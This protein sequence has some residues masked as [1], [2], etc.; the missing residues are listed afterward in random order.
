MLIDS[1]RIYK[2][3]NERNAIQRY[4][5]RKIFKV[6]ERLGFH[7]VGDHF[8]EPIPN[9]N[10]IRTRYAAGPRD[11]PALPHASWASYNSKICSLLRKHID[12]YAKHRDFFGYRENNYYFYGVDAFY[13][14]AL[15]RETA[16]SRVLEIGQGFST[17]I[18]LAALRQNASNGSVS[19]L[20]S[21]DPYARINFDKAPETPFT[22]IAK[23]LEDA[24]TDIIEFLHSGDLLFIDSSHIFKFGSDVQILFEKILPRLRPGVHV[25]VHDIFT[26][27]DYPLEWLI[28]RRFWN[29][30]YHLE[31]FL[32]FNSAFEIEAPIF[33]AVKSGE[34]EFL[35][36]QHRARE[37]IRLTGSS[38]Y[39]V[40][41]GQTNIDG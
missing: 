21:I 38:F 32:A 28:Q 2:I 14:Y 37:W 1:E 19:E 30:Q 10:T 25:H 12:D 8:Y 4:I 31:G 40:R 26:P 29:E 6:A 16:P 13:Y 24:A 3:R 22:T 35:L 15:L 39:F 7:V 18:A 17:R 41:A 11:L 23:K 27:Y 36:D 9:S 33:S 34:I 20:I 5:A